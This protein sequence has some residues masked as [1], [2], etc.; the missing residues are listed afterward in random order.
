MHAIAGEFADATAVVIDDI[1][2]WTTLEAPA[3]VN[4]LLE[5]FLKTI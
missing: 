2:H 4:D 5:D 1:G 3:E